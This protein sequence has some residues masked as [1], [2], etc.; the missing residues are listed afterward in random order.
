MRKNGVYIIHILRILVAL[1]FILSGLIKINDP[2]GFSYKLDEYFEVFHT[3]ALIPYSVLFAIL[4]CS[5]EIVLGTFLMLKTRYTFVLKCLLSLILFFCFLTFYSAFFNVVKTCGCFGDA[6]PLK[7]WI[8]FIKDLFLFIA[9]VILYYYRRIVVSKFLKKSFIFLISTVPILLGLYTY[10]TLPIIDFLPYKVGANIP[11]LMKVKDGA[12]VSEYQILYDLKN[13]KTGEQKTLT[14]K[15]YLSTKIYLDT[16]WKLIKSS[17]PQLIKQGDEPVIKDLAIYDD[18]GVSYTT[19]IFDNPYYNLLVVA[20]NLDDTNLQ[21][22]GNINA[23]AIN[24]L[25]QYHVKTILLTASSAKDAQ[26][27]IKKMNLQMDVFYADAVPLKSMVRS[28][29]GIILMK[30]GIIIQKWPGIFSPN[31]YTLHSNYLNK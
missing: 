11:S 12:A 31:F 4:L 10:F 18:Q 15:D 30:N 8:S 17:E 1:I 19:E 26:H 24:S 3:T 27:L 7:P 28:N 25:E 2:L 29:P 16:T 5:L 13:I 21:Y 6:L 14:D 22:L 20:Y 23:L 9:I